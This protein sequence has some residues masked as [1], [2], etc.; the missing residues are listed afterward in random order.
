MSSLDSATRDYLE[1]WRAEPGRESWDDVLAR[2]ARRSRGRRPSWRIALATAVSVLGLLLSVPALGIGGRLTALFAD[3][4]PPGLALRADIVRADGTR[5][6]S[7]TLRTSRLFLTTSGRRPRVVPHPFQIRGN[8]LLRGVPIRWSLALV[9]GAAD[10]A[11]LE[12]TDRS[13]RRH[14][15]RRLCGP[16][17]TTTTGQLL[18]RRPDVEALFDRR[19]TIV[20][21]TS[22][23]EA[24]GVLRLQT[25]R[26]SVRR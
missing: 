12:R 21:T 18:L 15:V 8:R 26:L 24:R 17:P 6:G 2:A 20:V 22:A 3:S 11:R 19:M 1:Q 9:D 5:V 4:K 13:K 14:V 10:Q 16:C 7:L 23:D 25:F